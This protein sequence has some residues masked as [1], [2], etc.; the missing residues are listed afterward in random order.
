MEEENWGPLSAMGQ[1]VFHFACFVILSLVQ[2]AANYSPW[3]DHENSLVCRQFNI[4]IL[5]KLQ[6]QHYLVFLIPKFCTYVCALI[7][8][9]GRYGREIWAGITKTH[10]KAQGYPHLGCHPVLLTRSG[11]ASPQGL[12]LI[13]QP[14]TSQSTQ[15]P[16]SHQAQRHCWLSP[17]RLLVVAT[18][19]LPV[20]S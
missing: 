7:T 4:H 9:V 19:I 15:T 13:F 2:G 3:I 5:P 8:G 20:S 17:L 6:N 11:W 12:L 1:E 16:P 10:R 14:L 18:F